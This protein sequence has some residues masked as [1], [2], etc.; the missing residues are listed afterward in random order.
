MHIFNFVGIKI[1]SDS[2]SNKEFCSVFFFSPLVFQIFVSRSTCCSYWISGQ[3]FQTMQNY[4]VVL[5]T[6]RWDFLF[7]REGGSRTALRTPVSSCLQAQTDSV[8]SGI[9][10]SQCQALSH[11]QEN[12]QHT[13]S[14]WQSLICPKAKSPRCVPGS[15]KLMYLFPLQRCLAKHLCS[16]RAWAK[17]PKPRTLADLRKLGAW[18]CELR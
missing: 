17:S 11:T 12:W 6:S 1:K 7:W 2:L 16:S 15:H 13:F 10:Q 8:S 14:P 18:S 5:H 4:H 3:P 9:T